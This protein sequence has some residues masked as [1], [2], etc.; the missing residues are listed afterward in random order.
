MILLDSSRIFA[1]N[2]TSSAIVTCQNG[3]VPLPLSLLGHQGTFIFQLVLLGLEFLLIYVVDDLSNNEWFPSKKA[4]D[5]DEGVRLQ[6]LGYLVRLSL[7]W[8]SMELQSFSLSK[9]LSWNQQCRGM[10]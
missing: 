1:N 3:E 10:I 7:L 9:K 4:R 6:S 8:P 5:N 2:D